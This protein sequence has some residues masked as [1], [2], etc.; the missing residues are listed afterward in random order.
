MCI[1]KYDSGD[2]FRYF[3]SNEEFFEYI[4]SSLP[5]HILVDSF[6]QHVSRLPAREIL[7]MSDR[8]Y[9]LFDDDILDLPADKLL[10]FDYELDDAW[11]L[12]LCPKEVFATDAVCVINGLATFFELD[13][14]ATTVHE[15][16]IAVVDSDNLCLEDEYPS[17]GA[18]LWDNVDGFIRDTQYHVDCHH[19]DICIE[20]YE[21]A[22]SYWEEK[23][24]WRVISNYSLP[25]AKRED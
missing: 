25:D 24:Y 19:D 22:V 3:D 18:A 14:K 21:D 20:T 11:R 10:V 7:N 1:I 15:L 17:P 4:H 9:A 23:Q 8:V 12:L 13:F 2:E 5:T 16:I 6:D